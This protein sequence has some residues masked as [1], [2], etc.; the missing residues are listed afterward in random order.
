M[1]RSRSSRKLPSGHWSNA[2]RS[3]VLR[4][5]GED[6]PLAEAVNNGKVTKAAVKARLRMGLS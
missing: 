2:S 5:G 3:T 1:R 6:G 4:V